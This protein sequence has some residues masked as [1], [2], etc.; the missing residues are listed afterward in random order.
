MNAFENTPQFKEGDLVFLKNGHAP[1]VVISITKEQRSRS[2][3]GW[4]IKCRY[5]RYSDREYD[6]RVFRP[7]SDYKP[8]VGNP[9][10]HDYTNKRPC[11]GDEPKKEINMGQKLYQTLEETPRFGTFLAKNSAGQ[12]VLEMKGSTNVEAFDQDKLEEVK[13]YTISLKLAN[14][15]EVSIEA[16]KDKVKEGDVLL[17]TPP[18]SRDNPY[19]DAGRIFASVTGINTGFT[20]QTSNLED[21]K[22]VR[23]LTEAI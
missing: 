23:V 3:T 8:Y 10:L 19:G 2:M 4:S 17:V 21:W 9:N 11:H 6:S 20:G 1:Q 7:E 16:S 12:F 15:K 5:Y 14:E 18:K 13:P 22:A